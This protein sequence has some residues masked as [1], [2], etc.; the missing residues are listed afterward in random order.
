MAQ[1]R[2]GTCASVCANT[3]YWG[4]WERRRP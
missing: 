2:I 1:M 3:H 4:N